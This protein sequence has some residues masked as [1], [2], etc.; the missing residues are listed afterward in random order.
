MQM[1]RKVEVVLGARSKESCSPSVSGAG[2]QWL[3]ASPEFGARGV[4]SG[5]DYS[6]H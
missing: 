1:W 6:T 4:I 5:P 2:C 3:A